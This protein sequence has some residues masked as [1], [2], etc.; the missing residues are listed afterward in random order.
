MIKTILT[1]TPTGAVNV[2]DIKFSISWAQKA[3]LVY[4]IGQYIKQR[5]IA[6]I[7][8]ISATSYYVT[9]DN[10]ISFNTFLD[11]LV[12]NKIIQFLASKNVEIFWSDMVV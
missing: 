1:I 3:E 11:N 2:N 6:D 5:K 10:M 4:E 8:P 12:Y 9:W 7:V